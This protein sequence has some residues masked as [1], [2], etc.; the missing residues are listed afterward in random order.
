FLGYSTRVSTSARRTVSGNGTVRWGE[1]YNGD[2]KT[3]TGGVALKPGYHLIVDLTYDRNEVHLPAGSF[4]TNLVRT[5]LTYAFTPQTVMRSFI[6]YNADTHQVSSNVRFNW[7][8]QPL[9]DLYIVYNNTQDT[10]T[11]L[12]R[13]RAVAVKLTKLLSF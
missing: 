13:E 8:F 6:Q 1:F 10:L 12:T 11:G 3:L 5:R 2:Y 9:S 4:T 7:T